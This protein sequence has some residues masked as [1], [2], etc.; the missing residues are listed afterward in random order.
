MKPLTPE[1]RDEIF[2]RCSTSMP[3]PRMDR[4]SINLD[5]FERWL[6]ENTE[7]ECECGCKPARKHTLGEGMET[8]EES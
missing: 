7:E 6:N 3:Y 4:R 1:Q 5:K 2:Y 8:Q